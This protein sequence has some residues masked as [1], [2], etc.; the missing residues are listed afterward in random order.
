[1]RHKVDLGKVEIC[2]QLLQNIYLVA[3]IIR[4]GV[5]FSLLLRWLSSFSIAFVV[6]V[7][8]LQAFISHGIG[9]CP[10]LFA[11]WPE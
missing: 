6:Y 11:G 8:L 7:S 4:S 2:I 3:D 10:H 9:F 5:H 1:M